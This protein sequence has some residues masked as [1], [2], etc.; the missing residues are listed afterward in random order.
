MQ[1]YENEQ[2]CTCHPVT[3]R[4]IS[5]KL[6][7]KPRAVVADWK[8]CVFKSVTE[9]CKQR[10]RTVKKGSGFAPGIW[11]FIFFYFF[12][13]G[14]ASRTFPS[15]L[16]FYPKCS[17]QFLTLN[18]PEINCFKVKNNGWFSTFL[19]VENKTESEKS[20]FDLKKGRTHLHDFRPFFSSK[21]KPYF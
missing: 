8:K 7:M 6:D 11:R 16:P 17:H 13:A 4:Y 21:K 12:L 1:Y 5:S 19:T 3:S 9:K 10:I 18:K 14:N 2:L 15:S 20:V